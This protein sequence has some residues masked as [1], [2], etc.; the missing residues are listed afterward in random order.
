MREGEVVL[1]A[2]ADTPFSRYL[3]DDSPWGGA[4]AARPIRVLA[5]ISNPVDLLARYELPPVDVEAEREILASALAGVDEIELAFLDAPVTPE[6]L[7]G[8]LREGYHVL[9][10]VG[11][12]AFSARRGQAALYLQDEA[13]NARLVRDDDLA[14]MLARLGTPPV[15]VVL[16]ACQSAER[17]MADASAGLAP[18]L[19]SIGIPAVLAMRDAV[20]IETAR[21]FGA[22]YYRRLLAH[23]YVDLATN[24]ARS[25]L[26]VAGRPD[27]DTP[28]LFMRLKD[29]RLFAPPGSE[30]P[31]VAPVQTTTPGWQPAT[32]AK[33]TWN[34]SAL[35]QLLTAAFT[36]RELTDLC[37]DHFPRV[38]DELGQGMGK[39][40]KVQRL[41]EHCLRYEEVETLLGLVRERNPAQYARFSG[42][43]RP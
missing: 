42:Q 8:A 31:P 39:S 15:L 26:L 20:S 24:E 30:L 12:G 10:F 29:G 40:A 33:A 6:R 35:R 27:A 5:V 28:V 1:A 16:A 43:L 22:T 37:Y 34:R 18:R 2:D 23:G 14:G 7:H 21:K 9:H 38:Y 17:S 13:G 3:P 41:L 25:T 11:H 19:I 4:V 36:D 32:D